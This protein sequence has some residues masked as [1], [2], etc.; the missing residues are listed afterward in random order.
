MHLHCRLLAEVEESPELLVRLNEINRR[1]AICTSFFTSR[2]FMRSR[3][4]PAAPFVSDH[5]IH[6]LDYFCQITDGMDTLL[7]TDFGGRTAFFEALP[8]S[9][10]H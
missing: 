1:S 9:L 10:R 7:Q 2:A 6:A 4:L 8:S 5:L 3:S